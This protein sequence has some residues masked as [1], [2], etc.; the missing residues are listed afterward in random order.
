MNSPCTSPPVLRSPTE[1]Q[2]IIAAEHA[3]APFLLWRSEE[4][5]QQLLVLH[6]DR[7]RVTIGRGLSADVS[8]G[9]DQQVSREHALLER[10]GSGWTLI[11]DG[12]SRN[13]SFING[14]RV[15]GRRRLADR[16]QLCVGVT[17][18]IY[19]EPSPTRSAST[20]TAA[21]AMPSVR[22]TPM[23]RKILIALCRPIFENQ[24]PTPATNRQIAEEV[25]LG[26]DAVKAHLRILFDRYG[27]GSDVPQNAEARSA[28]G[29]RPRIRGPD[30]TRLLT[31]ALRGSDRRN[32]RRYCCLRKSRS[33]D[34][35]SVNSH[36]ALAAS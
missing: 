29:L 28:R 12:L 8:L 15:V 11:D 26:V 16:D 6:P 2:E 3:G 13:G 10:V 30:V 34:S 19:R 31:R 22:L 32:D 27:I 25:F 21:N 35:H 24:S 23:Q 18:L 1:L 5:H 36:S 17:E 33:P 4:G 14:I 20:V 7:W 9:W